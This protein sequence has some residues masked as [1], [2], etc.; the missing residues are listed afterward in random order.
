[1]AAVT[2][3]TQSPLV[4]IGM[5]AGAVPVRLQEFSARMAPVASDSRVDGEESL[6]RVVE[7]NRPEGVSRLVAIFALPFQPR[8]VRRPMAALA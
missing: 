6:V 3:L 7:G 1:M 8:F 5:T 4:K 2:I